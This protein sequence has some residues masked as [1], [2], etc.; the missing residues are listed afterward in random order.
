MIIKESVLREVI[1]QVIL[2]GWTPP[3]SG[4]T[5]IV[6]KKKVADLL[7][8]TKTSG[9]PSA[10][11][12]Y[13]YIP[14]G[15]S[16]PDVGVTVS[17]DK[18]ANILQLLAQN[19][20]AF[21]KDK[22]GDDKRNRLKQLIDRNQVIYLK[23]NEHAKQPMS[24]DE[25]AVWDTFRDTGIEFSATTLGTLAAIA[26][27]IPGFQGIAVALE[28]G[29]NTFD[30]ASIVNNL[31][32]K[33]FLGAAFSFLG[34]LPG[35]NALG[36]IKKLSLAK[37]IIPQKVAEE[38]SKVFSSLRSGKFKDIVS[39]V[40]S[41][42]ATKRDI[43][44]DGVMNSIDGSFKALATFFEKIAKEDPEELKVKAAKI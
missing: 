43:D 23:G 7:Y 6:G 4:A 17:T 15:V 12:H 29:G 27:V 30:L 11:I 31:D 33:N 40:V 24:S 25:T 35:G 22:K 10:A 19:N 9:N 8:I 2:E 42:Y 16:K 39:K 21:L 34:L 13:Y 18:L 1:R 44:K 37:D 36:I 38:I 28:A 5:A 26:A 14:K 32:N 3:E 20:S 41:A